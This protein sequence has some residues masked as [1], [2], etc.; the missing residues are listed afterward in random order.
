[1]KFKGKWRDLEIIIW[2]EER[3]AFEMVKK[4]S[5]LVRQPTR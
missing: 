2:T 3:K 4:L 5:R 1:M